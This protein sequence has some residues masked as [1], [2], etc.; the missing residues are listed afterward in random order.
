MQ[1]QRQT[2]GKWG[3]AAAAKFLERHGFKVL[4]RNFHTTRG[5]IDIVA[6]KAGDFYFVEVK[7]RRAG[8]LATDLAITPQKR[9]RF[10]SAVATYC[11]RHNIQDSATRL[12]HLFVTIAT[13]TK[14]VRFR[15]VL[16]S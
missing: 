16:A 15:L 13:H 2:L 11:V 9:R 6:Q 5:E 14:Q 8:P 7:T 10:A 1:N 3:E 12:A 4:A